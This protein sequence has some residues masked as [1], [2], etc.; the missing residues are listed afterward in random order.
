[1]TTAGVQVIALRILQQFRH[2]R[3]TL[4]LLFVAPIVILGLFDVLLRDSSNR[5]PVEVV[6]L[7]HGPLGAAVA[8]SLER[9]G[10]VHAT[11]ASRET[12]TH[13]LASASIAAYVLLPEDF[14][15]R[16]AAQ[17]DIAPQVH[18]EGSQPSDTQPVLLA[19]N[20]AVA[21][22][23]RQVLAAAGAQPPTVSVQ[24]DYL[25]G[26]P[27]LDTLDYFG[28]GV[29]GL[30]VFF[31]VFIITII[32]FLRERSQGTLE[33][34]MASPLRRGDLVV[35]YMVGFGTI[36]VVQAVEV[37]AFTLYVLHVHNEGNV[38]IVLLLT[39]L[40][41]LVAVNLGIFLSTFASTE[42]QAVQFIPLA[43]LPQVL[44]SGIIFPVS[45][46]PAWLQA[47]SNILPLTYGVSGLRDVMLRG[48]DLSSGSVLLSI[49]V[50][51]AYVVVLIVAAAA[52]L[53]RQVA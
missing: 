42:F 22:A 1:M 18:L 24:V 8:S 20:Q 11:A 13:D 49:G 38:G 4:V 28:A 12:A 52:T 7:D 31:L 27:E 30:V 41:T 39:L 17:R 53:R 14:S 2:D 15:A 44:L 32:A 45:A 5:P 25:H 46:E 19:V 9:S 43:I 26:G 47:V 16:A 33:R 23:S 29:V 37:L 51:A 6:N 21:T 10:E 36:A 35:G 34:L 50:L 3:R 48:A 40:M